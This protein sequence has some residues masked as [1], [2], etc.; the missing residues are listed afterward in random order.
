MK[1]LLYLTISMLLCGVSLHAQESEAEKQLRAQVRTLT[2]LVGDMQHSF[3]IL[4]K[5]IDD[6]LWYEKVGD[7]AYIDKVRIWGPPRSNPKP[8]GNKFADSYLDN[9]LTFYAYTFIPRDIDPSDKHPLIVLV[10][11]GIHSN[12]SSSS[13][14]V[15]RELVSQ[16]YIVVSP[17]YRGSTGYGKGMYR[18]IDYGGYE[19]E[20]ALASRD[21]MVCNY[22]IVDSARVGIIGWSHGGMIALNNICRYPDSYACA[23][24]GVPVSDVTYRLEY[25]YAG[26]TDY[27]AADYHI[28]ATPQENPD[29]YIRRSPTTY[30]HLLRKPL[31][32]TTTRNDNDV[33]WLEVKRMIDSLDRHGK[34]FE[35]EIY[36]PM[37]GGHAFDRIDTRE[38]T[39]A[40]YKVH[41]FLE[42]HLSPPCPFRTYSDMRR[43]AYRFD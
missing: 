1:K 12:L 29:E 8:T 43:A 19:N 15:I 36:D 10:H 23:M 32:I 20:D 5:R 2:D 35:Y 3:D 21:Y 9:N 18:N 4:E 39:E 14:H 13:A 16:G 6:V 41:K 27:F 25:K 42:K 31:M 7:L 30:A 24:A 22:S 28:G 26:Y 34:T 17:E 40:R 33:S 38:S 37:P 11:S